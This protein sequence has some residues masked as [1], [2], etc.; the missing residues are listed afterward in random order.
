[1]PDTAEVKPYQPWST[2]GHAHA[3]PLPPSQYA[4]QC[5]VPDLKLEQPGQHTVVK[6]D[7]HHGLVIVN[8]NAPPT[9]TPATL[10]LVVVTGNQANVTLGN[11]ENG[12][13]VLFKSQQ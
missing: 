7:H 8:A 10:R 6:S 1:M 11:S 13:V 2:P 3:D 9:A 12:V 5:D 4:R